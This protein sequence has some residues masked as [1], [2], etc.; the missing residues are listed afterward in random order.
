M[1]LLGVYLSAQCQLAGYSPADP[2]LTTLTLAPTP[3]AASGNS[4]HTHSS[5]LAIRPPASQSQHS[6]PAGTAHGRS[7]AASGS[8]TLPTE[9]LRLVAM[10]EEAL[11]VLIPAATSHSSYMVRCVLVFLLLH[12]AQMLT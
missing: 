2:S 3:R 8:D 9:V 11:R 10:W 7:A 5:S 6:A 12:H 1:K 4:S